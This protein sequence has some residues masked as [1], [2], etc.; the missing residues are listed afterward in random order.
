MKNIA[1]ALLSSA[2]FLE[3]SGDDVLDPDAAVRA[4]EQIAYDLKHA[5]AAEVE[6]LRQVSAEMAETESKAGFSDSAE[7]FASFLETFGVTAE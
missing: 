3:L 2:A 4:M 1:R 5:T 7:F 6:L